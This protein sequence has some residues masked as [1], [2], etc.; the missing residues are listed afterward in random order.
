LLVGVYRSAGLDVERR[1]VRR[2]RTSADRLHSKVERLSGPVGLCANV[3]RGR[4]TLDRR[5]K[6]FLP[7]TE[8]RVLLDDIVALELIGA[9]ETVEERFYRPTDAHRASAADGIAV[10]P[11]HGGPV[12]AAGGPTHRLLARARPVRP[13][14]RPGNASAAHRQMASCFLRQASVFRPVVSLKS[15]LRLNYSHSTHCGHLAGRSP[16]SGHQ[17]MLWRAVACRARVRV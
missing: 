9:D 16:A 13:R 10:S 7:E 8:R 5:P 12:G 1:L 11:T 4:E 2:A 14:R 17:R 15:T 3:F 6:Q